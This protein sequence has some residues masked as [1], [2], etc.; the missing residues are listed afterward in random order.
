MGPSERLSATAPSSTYPA[1]KERR[2]EGEK[3]GA[4]K[5]K[6]RRKIGKGRQAMKD[7][8]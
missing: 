8:H 5:E 6:E 2:K 3:E 4:R 1:I 7:R